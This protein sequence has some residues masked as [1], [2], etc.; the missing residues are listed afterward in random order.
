MSKVIDINSLVATKIINIRGLRVIIDSDVAE[1]YN[2]ETKRINEAVRNNPDKFPAGYLI[3]LTGTEWEVVKSKFSTS[4]L[5]G[6][7]VKLPTAFA[8]RGLYMLATIL[9]SIK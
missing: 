8:E 4:P 9:K 3:E 6:G 1:L 7:K 5:G 2:V